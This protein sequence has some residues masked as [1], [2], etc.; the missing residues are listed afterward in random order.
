M[1][2]LKGDEFVLYAQDIVALDPQMENWPFQEIFVRFREEDEKLLPPG[3]FFPVLEDFELLPFLDRWVVNRL[4]RWVRSGLDIRPDWKIPRSNVNLSSVTLLDPEF[5]DYVRRYVDDSFLSNGALA[6]EVAWRDAIDNPEP[7]R[8]LMEELRPYGCGFTL[9]GFDGSKDAFAVVESV[10]PDFVKISPVIGTGAH[11]D[12]AL[13][14]RVA[15][16]SHRSR[17][18]NIKTIAEQIESAGA[19]EK[20]R[21]ARIDFA[22]GFEIAPV[23]AL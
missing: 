6:F 14:D 22:Q 16:I 4:A 18:M 3:S 13:A 11:S 19:L 15:E 2:A 17:V 12:P 20:L 21:R 5:G 1:A 23:K 7:L 10:A 8:L 9:A